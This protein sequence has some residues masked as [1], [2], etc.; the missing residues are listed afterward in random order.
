[1]C[2]FVSKVTGRRCHNPVL[3][4][5]RCT[6]V[7]SLMCSLHRSKRV[8][9]KTRLRLSS[10]KNRKHRKSSTRS[11]QSISQ[12]SKFLDRYLNSNTQS[13]IEYSDPENDDNSW[14]SIISSNYKS[15]EP[16]IDIDFS[17]DGDSQFVRDFDVYS[18]EEL[19]LRSKA[20]LEKLQ[21]LYLS[22]FAHLRRELQNKKIEY[23]GTQNV[24]SDMPSF[25]NLS[26][27]EQEVM[28][29]LTNYRKKSGEQVLIQNKLKLKVFDRTGGHNTHF[30][31]KNK[32]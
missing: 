26:S 25:T 17:D 31:Q 30:E 22:Q 16:D 20:R 24:P 12:K 6:S 11:S 32:M 15:C 1:M 3:K 19:I 21:S 2:K 8:Q 9:A 29:A 14:N 4:T 13:P 5:E 18:A 28:K 7:G 23:F 10:K 27:K